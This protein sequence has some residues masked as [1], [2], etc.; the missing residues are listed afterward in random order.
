M[1]SVTSTCITVLRCHDIITYVGPAHNMSREALNNLVYSVTGHQVK[2]CSMYRLHCQ[3]YSSRAITPCQL[4]NYLLWCDVY[5]TVACCVSV[6]TYGT[7]TM[8]SVQLYKSRSVTFHQL[9]TVFML[10]IIFIVFSFGNN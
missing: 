3:V 1:I 2:R 4:T 10:F 5:D 6:Y 9:S 7:N 8:Y